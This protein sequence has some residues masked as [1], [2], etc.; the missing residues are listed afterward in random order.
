M[1]SL[2]LE[3]KHFQYDKVHKGVENKCSY[4]IW[5]DLEETLVFGPRTLD[6]LTMHAV[7]LGI[8]DLTGMG[9]DD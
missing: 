9:D 6:T 1:I 5:D 3:L 8:A 4:L 2:L 7:W